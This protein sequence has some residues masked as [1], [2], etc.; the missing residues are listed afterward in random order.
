MSDLSK[1]SASE[2]RRYSKQTSLESF[3]ISAQQKLKDTAVLLIG[4]GG[5]GSPAAL[6]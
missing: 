5:V 3:G 6:F 4:V 1:L 2:I